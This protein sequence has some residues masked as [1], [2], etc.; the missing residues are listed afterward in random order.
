MN[1]RILC[2]SHHVTKENQLFSFEPLFTL[3]KCG[4]V[5]CIVVCIS[6]V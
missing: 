3:H 2:K 1:G 5:L 6:G 4:T